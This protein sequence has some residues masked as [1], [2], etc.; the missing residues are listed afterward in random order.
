[1]KRPLKDSQSTSDAAKHV[2]LEDDSTDN[3]ADVKKIVCKGRAPVDSLCTAKVGIAHVYYEQDGTVYDAML[4]QTNLQHNNNKYYLL[5]L[6]E[7]DDSKNY[8]VW[9]RWGRVGKTGQN[10]FYDKTL[11]EWD[12]R[13]CFEK[14]QGK[15]DLVHLDYGTEI[16]NQNALPQPDSKSVAIV[17]SM[18]PS[19]VQLLIKLICDLKSMEESVIEL[20][21]DA[22]RAPLGKLKKA[23]IKEGYKA[24]TSISNCIAQLAQLCSGSESSDGKSSGKKNKRV[25]VNA[26]E[27]RKIEQDLLMACNIFYTRVPHDFG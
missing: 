10:K 3:K 8:S 5:Q 20:K 15:Y 16:Q 1:M 17:E 2:K 12:C 25:K 23:Q 6:L 7:D 19:A 13:D 22:R 14:V 27:K 26:S 9:F 18:L 4:N 21:Y 24:L 11:N